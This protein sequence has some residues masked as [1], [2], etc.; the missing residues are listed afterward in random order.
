M[1]T[2]NRQGWTCAPLGAVE[3]VRTAHSIT[4]SGIGRVE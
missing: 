3:A 4:S 2:T 1:I